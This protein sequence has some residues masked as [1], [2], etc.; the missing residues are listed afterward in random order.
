MAE[1][2]PT[3]PASLDAQPN[4]FIFP[5]WANLLLP[6]I[7]VMAVG[8]G[9]YATLIVGL[10]FSPQ[11]TDV[12]YMPEQPVPYSHELHAGKL[13]IDC[14]YCHTTVEDAAF[15]ASPPT[16]TCMNCHTNVNVANPGNIQKIKESW[17]TGMPVQWVKVHDLPDYVFFNHSAHVNKGVGCATCHGQ[18]DQM[19]TVYQAKELSMSWCLTCHREPEKFLRPRDQVTNMK[20]SAKDHPMFADQPDIAESV[21]QLELGKKLKVEY[22]V[23]DTQYMQSCSTCHR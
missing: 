15:A 20:W 3:A 7:I 21:A 6:F 14:R 17:N 8:G 19:P 22:Q 16:Q 13:G 18:V 2:P 23:R 9:L 4:R 11:A 10:G 1:T 5:R 12:G